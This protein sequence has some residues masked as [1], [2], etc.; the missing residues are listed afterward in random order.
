MA[1]K[2]VLRT[3]DYGY[4][5]PIKKNVIYSRSTKKTKQVSVYSSKKWPFMLTGFKKATFGDYFILQV[6][7]GEY[8]DVSNLVSQKLSNESNPV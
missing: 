6:N 4:S 8:Q 5:C 3:F 1:D 7:P 2:I